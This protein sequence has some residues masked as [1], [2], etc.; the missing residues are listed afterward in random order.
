LL[1][2]KNILISQLKQKVNHSLS[3]QNLHKLFT[4][5]LKFKNNFFSSNKYHVHN[6]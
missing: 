4:V 6:L 1:S 3:Q 5:K 2:S